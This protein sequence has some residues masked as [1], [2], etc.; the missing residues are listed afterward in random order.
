MILQLTFALQ[1]R[2][3]LKRLYVLKDISVTAMDASWFSFIFLSLFKGYSTC[4]E[5]S[6]TAHAVWLT[7]SIPIK[8]NYN[9]IK[10]YN[11]LVYSYLFLEFSQNIFPLLFIFILCTQRECQINCIKYGSISNNRCYYTILYIICSSEF[12]I[13]YR[14]YIRNIRAFLSMTYIII[15]IF[16]S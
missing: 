10:I 11:L 14:I 1:G 4:T 13:N 7:S 8:E 15:V 3:N 12:V 6:R 5:I 2:G 16:C 9:K